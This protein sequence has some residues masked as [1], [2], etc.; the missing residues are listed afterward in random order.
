M[1]VIDYYSLGCETTTTCIL[2]GSGLGSR[3]Q[4]TFETGKRA[5]EEI[6]QSVEARACV[7]QY[8]Q[9]RGERLR[10]ITNF[11][12]VFESTIYVRTIGSTD[13]LYGIGERQEP[14]KNYIT[15]D[16]THTNGDSHSR[17]INKCK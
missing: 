11:I 10:V 9:V 17:A 1:M 16:T 15:I 2:G 5:G 14:N 13:Y 7:D 3:Q 12:H 4:T 8:V 6:V